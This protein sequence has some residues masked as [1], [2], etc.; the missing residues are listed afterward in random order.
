MRWHY[1]QKINAMVYQAIIELCPA[2]C[3]HEE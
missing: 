2:S 3:G 1:L